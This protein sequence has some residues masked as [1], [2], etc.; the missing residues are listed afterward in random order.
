MA[1]TQA[2]EAVVVTICGHPLTA[3]FDR[4]GGEKGIRHE[5]SLDLGGSTEA[6]KMSQ[7]LGPGAI[8]VQFG[9]SR[10]S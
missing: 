1:D 9:W 8:M 6:A 7:C 5:I 10:S 4:E 3:A 2:G